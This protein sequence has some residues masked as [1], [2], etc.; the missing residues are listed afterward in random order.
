VACFFSQSSGRTA[1]LEF[2]ST[3]KVAQ[4][5][6]SLAQDLARRYPPAIANY[7]AQVVSQQRVLGILEEVFAGV[8][9][10]TREHKLGWYKRARLGKRFRSELNELGYDKKFVDKAAEGLYLYA[11]RDPSLKI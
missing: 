6:E 11:S 3:R 1:I 9:N 2:L 5:A 4:L 7:P 10:F 8:I